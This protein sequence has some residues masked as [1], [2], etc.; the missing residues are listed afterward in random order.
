MDKETVRSLNYSMDSLNNEMRGKSSSYYNSELVAVYFSEKDSVK[1]N[2]VKA[3]ELVNEEESTSLENL[4]E[5]VFATLLKNLKSSNTFQVRT[6]IIPIEDSL[7]MSEIIIEEEKEKIDSAFA[8]PKNYRYNLSDFGF[9][10]KKGLGFV[11]LLDDY[12]YSIED[13][14][15]FNGELVYVIAFQPDR[16]LFAGNGKMTGTM[17][18]SA[19]SFAVLMAD[20][21]FAEGEHGTKVNLKFIAGVAFEEKG[22]SGKIIFQKNK[23]GK[24]IPKYIRKQNKNYVFFERN[25]VFKENDNR[26]D[27]MKIKFEM[28]IELDQGETQEWLVVDSKAITQTEFDAAEWKVAVPVEKTTKYNPEIWKDYNILAPTE[29]IREYEY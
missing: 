19:N 21:R 3:S 9:D 29:A 2:L 18:I 22:K 7:D 10:E 25:F 14:S 23:N 17:Y 4:R 13:I 26:A 16:G 27:R 8:S 5:N 28:T 15:T 24:Y 1:L 6:G 20:Y 12:E 11:T